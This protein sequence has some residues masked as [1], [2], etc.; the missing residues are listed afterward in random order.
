MTVHTI[1]L[2]DMVH[3]D[4]PRSVIWDDEAGTVAGEHYDVPWMQGMLAATPPVVMGDV[5]GTVTLN[6]PSHD[7]ADFLVLLGRAYWPVLEEPLRSTLPSVFDGVV[8]TSMKLPPNI[9][10]TVALDGTPLPPPLY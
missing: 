1:M 8:M 4:A 5:M 3:Y 10:G 6:D 9:A 2:P 7:P